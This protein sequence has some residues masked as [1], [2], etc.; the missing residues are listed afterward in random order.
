MSL[1]FTLNIIFLNGIIWM[2]FIMDVSFV[3][4]GVETKLLYNLYRLEFL[5]SV[6]SIT[7]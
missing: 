1:Y 2:A 4:S 5:C 3:L 6:Q 7:H